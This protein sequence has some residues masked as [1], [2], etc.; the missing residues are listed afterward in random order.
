MSLLLSVHLLIRLQLCQEDL[1]QQRLP[2][3]HFQSRIGPIQEN[4]LSENHSRCSKPVVFPS[5]A[6]N[7][8][9]RLRAADWP[10][11]SLN[12][13]DGK[14]LPRLNFSDAFCHCHRPGAKRFSLSHKLN[15]EKRRFHYGANAPRRLH[16]GI[17]KKLNQTVIITRSLQ[18]TLKGFTWFFFSCSLRRD[19]LPHVYFP[20]FNGFYDNR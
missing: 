11:K 17:N 15:K 13:A 12:L 8:L 2:L 16:V 4:I 9:M 14:C 5:F 3:R 6:A 20:F 1:L 18:L 10:A 7:L 19:T